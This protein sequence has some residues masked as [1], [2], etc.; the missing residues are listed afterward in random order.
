MYDN[1]WNNNYYRSDDTAQNRNARIASRL[2]KGSKLR[3]ETRGRDD[4][5]TMAVTTDKRSHNT[6]L[7][8]DFD[9]GNANG[10]STIRLDGRK[11]RTLFRLLST[12][13][14]YAGKSFAPLKATVGS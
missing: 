14:G 12:H 9:G 5:I 10:G 7:F 4:G 11:A 13:Y 1:F 6:Q 8:I 3:T 2:S